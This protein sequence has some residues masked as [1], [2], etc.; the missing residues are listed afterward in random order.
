MYPRSSTFT[1]ASSR[2]TALAAGPAADAHDDLVDDQSLVAGLAVEPNGDVGRSRSSSVMRTPA[3]TLMP[4]LVNARTTVC[5][6]CWSTPRE[7]LR[8]RFEDRD[9]GTDVDEER[10]ELAA[11]RAAADDRD[12]R[13]DRVDLQHVVGREHAPAVELESVD[14]ERAR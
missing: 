5:A 11:D 7:H 14:R 8:E 13:R 2:P 12:A 1:P 4:R 3:S 10:C 9:L 6:T